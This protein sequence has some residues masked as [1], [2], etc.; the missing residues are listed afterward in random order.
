MQFSPDAALLDEAL[1]SNPGG[2]FTE[3]PDFP[4]YTFPLQEG[5]RAIIHFVECCLHAAAAADNRFHGTWTKCLRYN[6]SHEI[7]P[8]IAPP[9]ALRCASRQWAGGQR[10]DWRMPDADEHGRR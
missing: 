7:S 9:V 2:I 5:Q 10:L 4:A 8:D 6:P 1:T 3:E